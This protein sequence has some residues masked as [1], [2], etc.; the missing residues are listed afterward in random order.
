M[1]LDIFDAMFPAKAGALVVD[2]ERGQTLSSG[3]IDIALVATFDSLVLLDGVLVPLLPSKNAE[4]QRTEAFLLAFGLCLER[5][6]VKVL[7]EA[8]ER[9]QNFKNTSAGRRPEGY[10]PMV[11]ENFLQE[12]IVV[13]EGKY[14]PLLL[15][16]ANTVEDFTKALETKGRLGKWL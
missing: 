3:T 6:L 5:A 12:W 8:E 1:N 13:L 11:L 9:R 7:V 14:H 15:A 10:V 16:K 2:L 4:V